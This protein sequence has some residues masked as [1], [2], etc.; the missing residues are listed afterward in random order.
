MRTLSSR[1]HV[2]CGL[3]KTIKHNGGGKFKMD[4]SNLK[5]YNAVGC[6]GALHALILS[7]PFVLLNSPNFSSYFSL[8]KF[9]R[10][11]FLIF[12]S[13]LCLISSHF[14]ITKC[15]ICKYVI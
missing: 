12:S 1:M 11:M 6:R 14:L 4:F 7:V 9:E 5:Y 8:N 2:V 10:S 3:R 15:L 13:L